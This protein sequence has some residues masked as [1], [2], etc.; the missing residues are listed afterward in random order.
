MSLIVIKI[1][2]YFSVNKILG[3]FKKKKEKTQKPTTEIILL[4]I[5]IFKT[6]RISEKFHENYLHSYNVFL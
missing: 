6:F 2:S 4:Y 5:R 1:P 3:V